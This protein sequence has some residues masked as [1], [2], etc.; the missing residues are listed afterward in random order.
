MKLNLECG[1]LCSYTFYEF[2]NQSMR[3]YYVNLI[4]GAR[5]FIYSRLSLFP[6]TSAA[7]GWFPRLGGIP[8]DALVLILQN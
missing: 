7:F 1:G 2:W 8:L 5:A 3:V 6:E 4:V